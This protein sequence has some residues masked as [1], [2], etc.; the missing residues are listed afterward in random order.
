[1]SSWK[2]VRKL[3]KQLK[4]LTPSSVATRWRIIDAMFQLLIYKVKQGMPYERVY[5]RQWEITAIVRRPTSVNN[6]IRKLLN[7]SP[8]ILESQD[9]FVKPPETHFTRDGYYMLKNEI[10]C[11]NEIFQLTH[12]YDM[13]KPLVEIISQ[14]LDEFDRYVQW[15]NIEQTKSNESFMAP[16]RIKRH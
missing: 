15:S 14:R 4:I 8:P 1:M 5:L 12:E 11:W 6:L 16:H 10:K 7:F 2:R 13:L 9:P 3:E